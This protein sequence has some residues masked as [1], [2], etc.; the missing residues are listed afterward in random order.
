MGLSKGSSQHGRLLL[1]R[2]QVRRQERKRENVTK[3]YP[4]SDVP[5]LGHTVSASSESPVQLTFKG[6]N[7][8]K[9]VDTARY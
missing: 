4:R 7:L 2:K 3:S 1:T 8:H 5:S 6:K 9:D